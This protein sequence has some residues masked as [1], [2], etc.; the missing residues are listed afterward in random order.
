[1][2]GQNIFFHKLEATVLTRR[3]YDNM[4]DTMVGVSQ[5]RELFNINRTDDNKDIFNVFLLFYNILK[6]KNRII[7]CRYKSINSEMVACFSKLISKTGKKPD[8]LI[9][10]NEKTFDKVKLHANGVFKSFLD[11]ETNHK[12]IFPEGVT[13]KQFCI[14]T[15]KDIDNIGLVCSNDKETNSLRLK[16]PI[17][18]DS[19]YEDTHYNYYYGVKLND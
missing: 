19:R 2:N 15:Y 8:S 6:N 5:Y 9:F 12:F 18:K 4:Y 17:Y 3:C 11:L 14:L 1:M 7:N 10:S 13:N 16:E